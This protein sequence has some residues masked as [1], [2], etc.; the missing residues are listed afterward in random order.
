MGK[1]CS[2]ARWQGIEKFIA[3]IIGGDRVGGQ[4][5]K[6]TVRRF[7]IKN[8]DFGGDCRSE[9]LLGECKA[10]DPA[11]STPFRKQYPYDPAK[12]FRVEVAWLDQIREEARKLDLIPFL[13]F[14]RKFSEKKDTHIILDLD[15]FIDLVHKAGYLPKFATLDDAIKAFKARKGNSDNE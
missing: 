9:F 12:T 14:N 15:V 4:A 5:I 8:D 6:G 11:I 1:Q 7:D 10:I 2:K 3:F 13:A